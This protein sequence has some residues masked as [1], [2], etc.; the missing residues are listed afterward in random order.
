MHWRYYKTELSSDFWT[1]TEFLDAMSTR[2][3]GHQ[4]SGNMA[5]KYCIQLKE[6]YIQCQNDTS[7][8][9]DVLGYN[10]IEWNKTPAHPMPPCEPYISGTIG[11][12]QGPSILLDPS[13]MYNTG[14]PDEL[15]AVTS[16]LLDQQ[17]S[18]MD[19]IISLNNA[20]FAPNIPYIH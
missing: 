8:K 2:W 20:N 18:D 15:T 12:G 11:S 3:S 13:E 5:I 14:S 1:L 10:E 9:L 6:T 7:F 16:I 4:A 17:Y 19:R